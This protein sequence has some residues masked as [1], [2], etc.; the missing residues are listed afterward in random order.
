[1]SDL[2][3]VS[4]LLKEKVHQSYILLTKKNTSENKYENT[5]SIKKKYEMID[6]F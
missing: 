2:F 6:I 3:T 4:F 1:M 5:S